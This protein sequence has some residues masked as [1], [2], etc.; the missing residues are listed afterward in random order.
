[1]VEVLTPFTKCPQGGMGLPQRLK[2]GIRA[3]RC[4]PLPFVAVVWAWRGHERH[5][6][7]HEDVLTIVHATMMA[8]SITPKIV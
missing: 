6:R 8:T 1:M 2:V 7:V 5:P 4:A 3:L